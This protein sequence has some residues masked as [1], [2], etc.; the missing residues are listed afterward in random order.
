M[1]VPP[2]PGQEAGRGPARCHARSETFGPGSVAWERTH[3]TEPADAPPR[4]PR[5]CPASPAAARCPVR[6]PPSRHG[7]RFPALQS[8][9]LL[10]YNSQRTQRGPV[11]PVCGERSAL[12]AGSCSPPAAAAGSLPPDPP[13]LSGGQGR[14]PSFPMPMFWHTATMEFSER[15]MAAHRCL[16]PRRTSQRESAQRWGGAE[17]QAAAVR[18]LRPRAGRW[19][20]GAQR[21]PPPG[22]DVFPAAPPHARRRIRRER[23]CRC[24]PPR[25]GFCHRHAAGAAAGARR[26]GAA[27]GAEQV[28]RSGGERR[29]AVRRPADGAPGAAAVA[30]GIQGA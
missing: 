17:R 12:H 3:G 6:G 29:G 28:L 22:G 21:S 25:P 27:A 15:T 1:Q 8:A 24:P 30:V 4:A 26:R 18:P 13:Y 16:P 5:G 20:E 2:A 19:R 11:A 10:A 7:E 14:L 23:W 9:A